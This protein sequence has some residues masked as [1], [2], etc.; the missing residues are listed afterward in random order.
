[1]ALLPADMAHIL[2][3]LMT[4]V[5]ET[6]RH[7]TVAVSLPDSLSEH[8]CSATISETALRDLPYHYRK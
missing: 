6:N 2:L 4:Q 8:E 1:M 7:V 5:P 3:G